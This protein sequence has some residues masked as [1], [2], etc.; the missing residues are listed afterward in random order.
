[1]KDW[2]R[3]VATDFA[4]I[5]LVAGC[6]PGPQVAAKVDPE[7]ARTALRTTLDA[8]KAGKPI[9]FLSAGSPS[10]VAQDFDWM[11]GKKLASYEVLGEGTPQDANLRVEVKLTLDGDTAAKKVAYIVGTSPK[12]TVFRAFE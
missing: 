7:A 5:L 12:L 9:E 8:W 1:M 11:Q 3:R 10:I 6:S 2:N 4:A